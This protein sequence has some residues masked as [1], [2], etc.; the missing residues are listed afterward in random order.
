MKPLNKFEEYIAR[1]IVKKRIPDR[2]RAEALIKET[3]IL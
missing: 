1:G 2:L 3:D